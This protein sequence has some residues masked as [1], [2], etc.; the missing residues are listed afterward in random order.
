M[1]DHIVTLMEQ[2]G[3]LL[4]LQYQSL[5]LTHGFLIEQH[6]GYPVVDDIDL[7]AIMPKWKVKGSNENSH[8]TRVLFDAEEVVVIATI[9]HGSFNAGVAG[10]DRESVRRTCAALRERVPRRDYEDHETIPVTFWT[11]SDHGPRQMT[12]DLDADQ[13]VTIDENYPG[14]AGALLSHM[15]S[16]Q[17]VPGRGGQLL[18]WH[19]VPGTGKTTAL[20]SLAREWRQWCDIHYI[21]DPEEFFGKGAAYMMN[22]LLSEEKADV[23]YEEPL[24]EGEEPDDRPRWRVLVLEDCGELLQ[25]D[26]RREVGQALSRLLNACDGMIG[27]GL[28]I[29]VLLTTNEPVEKL[30]EAVARPGRCAMQIEFGDFDGEAARDWLE[31]RGT[32]F[33]GIADIDLRRR[34]TLADLYGHLQHFQTRPADH[35][36][37]FR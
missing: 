23:A 4:D 5:R 35:S 3:E 22:V 33:D 15:M 24:N 16:G 11:N 2:S 26:A 32:S 36:V 30:H 9:S 34:Y 31:Q 27:R 20:R 21:V 29:M 7:F 19:G 6:I 18:L 13:W 17:F 28:R 1:P 37:G 25:P 14:D 8:S 10:N 12:R